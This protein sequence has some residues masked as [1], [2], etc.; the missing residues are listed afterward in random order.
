MVDTSEHERPE[1]TG[2]IA[3]WVPIVALIMGADQAAIHMSGRPG[4]DDDLA[5]TYISLDLSHALGELE[6]ALPGVTVGVEPLALTPSGVG[7][8]TVRAGI[9]AAITGARDLLSSIA[10][11]GTNTSGEVVTATRVGLLLAAVHGE[12]SRVSR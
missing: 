9:L 12:L 7:D 2:G 10:G 6:W 8:E 3:R 5:L 11:E 1:S 4:A